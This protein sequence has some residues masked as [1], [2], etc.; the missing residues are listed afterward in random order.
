MPTVGVVVGVNLSC[1][2]VAP[3]LDLHGSEV[4]RK[5]LSIGRARVSS[6]AIYSHTMSEATHTMRITRTAAEKCLAT[7]PTP[8]EVCGTFRRGAHFAVTQLGRALMD[9]HGSKSLPAFAWDEYYIGPTYEGLRVKGS[10][11]AAA[12]SKAAARRVCAS[13]GILGG[14]TVT[15]AHNN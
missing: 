1:T 2:T 5:K 7:H 6:V 14:F 4:M 8:Y 9:L 13:G 15:L 10:A 3:R 11:V 12:A